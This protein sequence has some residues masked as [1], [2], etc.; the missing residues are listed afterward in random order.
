MSFRSS[1]K[2]ARDTS[3]G[4]RGRRSCCRGDG[5]SNSIAKGTDWQGRRSD[6]RPR[7]CARCNTKPNVARTICC[8]GHRYHCR[9]IEEIDS[10]SHS[11]RSERVAKKLDHD[12]SKTDM[13]K[14]VITPTRAHGS[15]SRLQSERAFLTISTGVLNEADNVGKELQRKRLF[16]NYTKIGTTNELEGQN[17]EL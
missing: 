16:S 9:P 6:R 10:D 13:E 14:L 2:E 3:Q 4:R 1:S 8:G 11:V 7:R 15:F 12:R 5:L 17:V